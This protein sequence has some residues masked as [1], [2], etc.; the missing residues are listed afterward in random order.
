MRVQGEIHK[1]G[2]PSKPGLE[3]SQIKNRSR[4]WLL[5]FWHS[6]AEKFCTHGLEHNAFDITFSSLIGK[7][8]PSVG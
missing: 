1:D 5:W 3:M 8:L 7:M 2:V 4:I 6:Y